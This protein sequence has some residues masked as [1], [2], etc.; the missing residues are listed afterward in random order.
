MP[1]L[2]KHAET[3]DS[4]GEFPTRNTIVFVYIA[5]ASGEFPH[6]CTPRDNL[7]NLTNSLI[8]ICLISLP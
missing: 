1:V 7:I 2:S 5:L 8:Q 3:G 6:V 4:H